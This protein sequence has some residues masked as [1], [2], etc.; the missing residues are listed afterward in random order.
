MYG[1]IFVSS[2]PVR[3][4]GKKLTGALQHQRDNLMAMADVFNLDPKKIFVE[5]ATT[6]ESLSSLPKLRRLL[7]QAQTAGKTVMI[8]DFQR[9]FVR[10]P[11]PKRPALFKELAELGGLLRDLRHEGVPLGMLKNESR[12]AIVYALSPS[13]FR[14]EGTAGPPRPV[15]ERQRQTANARHVSAM[16]RMR[17]A[18]VRAERLLALQHALEAERGSLSHAD[19]AEAANAKGLTTTRGH[20]WS[21]ST[22]SRALR[23]LDRS[24]EP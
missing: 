18:D 4:T 20:P 22:V 12:D 13:R 21:G 16:V 5:K 19:L 6:V 17:K 3:S 10:A 8:D 1:Y 9:L 23:R 2:G 11:I 14:V 7:R 15:E 24:E